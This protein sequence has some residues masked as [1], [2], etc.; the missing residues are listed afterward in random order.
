VAGRFK[1]FWT[2]IGSYFMLILDKI[3]QFDVNH[4]F[5]I[6]YL[7]IYL[8]FMKLCFIFSWIHVLFNTFR[9]DDDPHVIGHTWLNDDDINIAAFQR[10]V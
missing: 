1:S 5:D 2:C 10:N 9:R 6:I 3:I 7:F 8:L 4:E